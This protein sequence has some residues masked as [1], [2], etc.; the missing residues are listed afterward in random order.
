MRPDPGLLYNFSFSPVEGLA[1]SIGPSPPE[2][3]ISASDN[4]KAN[5]KHGGV[6][7]EIQ[8][9]ALNFAPPRFIRPLRQAAG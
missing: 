9:I 1:L 5:E 2:S 3:R 6:Q 4:P 7:P 8:G